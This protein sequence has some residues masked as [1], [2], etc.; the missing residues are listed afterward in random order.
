MLHI[1]LADNIF[2]LKNSCHEGIPSVAVSLQFSPN[3][4]VFFE[5]VIYCWDGICL[6]YSS[7][8]VPHRKSSLFYFI[9]EGESSKYCKLIHLRNFCTLTCCRA[10]LPRGLIC[11]NALPFRVTAI[12]SI[13]LKAVFIEKELHFTL[14]PS[15]VIYFFAFYH[16]R[17]L[18]CFPVIYDVLDFAII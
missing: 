18:N 16:G 12:F 6:R 17:K 11:S 5:E 2:L 9:T 7:F 15:S 13:T 1:L 14:L 4:Q 3:I 10:N 8:L